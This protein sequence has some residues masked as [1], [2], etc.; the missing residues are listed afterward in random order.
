M[1]PSGSTLDF[2]HHTSP[3]PL[4]RARKTSNATQKVHGESEEHQ[5]VNNAPL[6]H[7]F[8]ADGIVSKKPGGKKVSRAFPALRQIA[9]L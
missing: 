9:R 6:D 2:E 5:F 3:R 7:I 8:I 4:K 1:P